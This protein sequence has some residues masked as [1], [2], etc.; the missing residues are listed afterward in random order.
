MMICAK[1]SPKSSGLN[2]NKA[3]TRIVFIKSFQKYDE[4]FQLYTVTQ[5]IL[6]VELNY[7]IKLVRKE[8]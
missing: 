1:Q 3:S 4:S 6:M 2:L 8:P 5:V 7:S